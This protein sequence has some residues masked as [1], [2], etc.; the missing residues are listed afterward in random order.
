MKKDEREHLAKVADLPCLICGIHGVEIHHL[1]S[2]CGMGQRSSHFRVLPLCS[3]H[4]RTGGF[5]VAIHGG[6]RE[7]QRNF[8]TEEELLK[9]VLDKIAGQDTL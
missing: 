5:G 2:G 6:T 9:K 1:R 3:V 7:F 4:H 8:G